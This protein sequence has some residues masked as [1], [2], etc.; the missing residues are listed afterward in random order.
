MKN[1]AKTP[2]KAGCRINAHL[3]IGVFFNYLLFTLIII[4]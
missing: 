3:A 1:K 4:C 2:M